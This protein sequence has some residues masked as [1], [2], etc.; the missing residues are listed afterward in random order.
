[1]LFNT[2]EPWKFAFSRQCNSIEDVEEN[3]WGIIGVPFDSTTSY[4][5]GTRLGPI[6]VREASYGLEVFNVEFN[7]NINNNFYD[8]G[9][10]NVIPGNCEETINIVKSNVLELMDYKIKPIL[11]GGEHSI[12][13]GAIEALKR[14]YDDLTIVHLDAH[15]DLADEL[16]GERYSHG[17]VMR[18]IHELGVSEIIQI[19]IRSASI[20]EENF[21]KGSN[22][23]T[24]KSREVE[25]NMNN[26]ISYLSQI[27]TPIYLTID[28]DVLDPS[29]APNVGNPTPMGITIKDIQDILESLVAKDIVGFDVVETAT[30][31]LGDIT[32]IS[33]AKIIYDFLTLCE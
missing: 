21:I 12:T 32:A 20:D 3:S 15:R 25:N 9:D 13:L 1:M 19:G 6:V 23:Q 17:T 33:A 22:I 29:F 26:L 7:N 11:I 18:R 31:K 10:S 14:Q 30:D 27:K 28:M 24:F 5:S 16:I 4:H 2:Y 8:F